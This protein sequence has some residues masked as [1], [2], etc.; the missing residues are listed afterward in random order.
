MNQG[1]YMQSMDFFRMGYRVCFGI[2]AAAFVTSVIL[3][4]VYDIPAIFMVRKELDRCGMIRKQKR[5]RNHYTM[6]SCRIP[7]GDPERDGQSTEPLGQA[8]HSPET[9]GVF[10]INQKLMV[11][12]T[13]EVIEVRN[14]PAR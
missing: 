12:H 13:E 2:A 3:F 10:V 1:Q 11:I 5:K 4:F 9:G 7:A 8:D 6:Q 14:T